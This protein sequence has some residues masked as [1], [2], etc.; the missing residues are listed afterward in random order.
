MKKKAMNMKGK[1]FSWGLS[2]DGKEE[3]KK[4]LLIK[5]PQN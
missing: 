4:F 5:T 3:I 1:S 2:F